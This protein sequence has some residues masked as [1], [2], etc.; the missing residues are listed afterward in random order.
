MQHALHLL[1]DRRLRIGFVAEAIGYTHQG[2]FASA[3]K[4][5]FGVRP[6]D[7]RRPPDPAL[8]PALPTSLVEPSEVD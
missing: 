4:A 2:T 8:S 5:H 1:R 6:K 3:F 7:V